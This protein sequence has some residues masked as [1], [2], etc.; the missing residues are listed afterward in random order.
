MSD[1]PTFTCSYRMDGS[2]WSFDIC[3]EDYDDADRRMAAIAMTGKVDGQLVNR[4][5]AYRGWYIPAW[6]WLKN[7]GWI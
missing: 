1:W 3:A 5:P 2:E 4:V 6:V 7:K